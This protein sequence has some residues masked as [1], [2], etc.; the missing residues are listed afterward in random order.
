MSTICS[1][2]CVGDGACDV[3]DG[4]DD[5]VGEADNRDNGD[6]NGD[7]WWKQTAR[8][9]YKFPQDHTARQTL[10]LQETLEASDGAV[11][12]LFNDWDRWPS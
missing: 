9:G 7:I 11:Q 5:N 3:D 6:D 10:R 2:G 4:D 12:S 1:D 8:D